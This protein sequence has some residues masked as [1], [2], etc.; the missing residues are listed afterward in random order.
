[1]NILFFFTI[2]VNVFGEDEFVFDFDFRAVVKDCGARKFAENLVRQHTNN[3][4]SNGAC[5]SIIGLKLI[6]NR[7]Q[8]L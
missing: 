6:S 7:R 3:F 4:K 8:S 1:M 2:Y 5:L